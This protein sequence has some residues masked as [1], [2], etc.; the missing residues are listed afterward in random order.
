MTDS[1][2]KFWIYVIELGSSARLDPAFE[3]EL[4]D[5]RKPCL[6]VGSTGKTIEERYADHLNGTWTQARAVRKHGAKRLRHDLAQGK[7]AFSRAKA[8][9]IE[10]R[11]AEQ[12][13]RLGFGVSQH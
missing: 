11:L 4:R 9:D 2:P 3:H 10:A 5:P 6:Y 12:L 1:P 7:Y 13:R 8:E